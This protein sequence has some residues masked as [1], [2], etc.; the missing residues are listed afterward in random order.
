MKA[1]IKAGKKKMIAEV[2]ALMDISLETM[3]VS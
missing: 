2:K 1:E 3:K